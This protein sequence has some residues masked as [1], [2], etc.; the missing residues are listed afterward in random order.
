MYA[1]VIVLLAS[2][3]EELQTIMYSEPL[4]KI[5]RKIWSQGKFKQIKDFVYRNR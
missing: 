5:C 4:R 2:H 3:P 1:Y